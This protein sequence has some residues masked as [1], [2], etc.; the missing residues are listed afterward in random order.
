MTLKFNTIAL[1]GNCNAAGVLESIHILADY[2][3]GLGAQVV[4]SALEDIPSLPES[5]TKLDPEEMMKAADL[6]I[7]VGGDGSMLTA[8]RAAARANIPLVG[9]NRGRLGFLADVSPGDKLESLE[10]ILTGNYDS[11]KRMLLRADIISKDGTTD[12]GSALNDIVIKRHQIGRMLDFQTS[13][14]GH[15]VNTHGGDGFIVA[16]PTGSTAYALSCGGP[17]VAPNLDAVVLTPIC[18]HTLSD[19]PLV[20]PATSITEVELAEG[21]ADNAEVSCDGEV[22][23]YL[24]TG[25]TLRVEAAAHR[26]ELIHPSGYDYYEILRNKLYWGRGNRKSLA[27]M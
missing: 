20:I 18:P 12:C 24:G 27:N 14:D 13:V 25:Q 22:T 21:H 5:A 15:Y 9:V 6:V 26:V 1:M 23:G 16:T 11:E 3:P 4:V 7:A 2:L 19:R 8:A 17:I 10:H